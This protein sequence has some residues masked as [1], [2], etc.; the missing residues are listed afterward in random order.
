LDDI[1]DIAV[2]IKEGTFEKSRPTHEAPTVDSS[3]GDGGLVTID[4]IYAAVLKMEDSFS[5]RL[6]TIEVTDSKS[7]LKAAVRAHIDELED[8]YIR[9]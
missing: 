6:R 5:A 8:M 2:S 7:E 3:A 4:P 1:A 9:L